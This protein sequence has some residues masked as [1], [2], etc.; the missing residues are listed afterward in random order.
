MH[1]PLAC[2]P[3]NLSEGAH[4]LDAV[5]CFGSARFDFATG[6]RKALESIFLI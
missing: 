1:S 2:S 6:G 4:V 5:P 3:F